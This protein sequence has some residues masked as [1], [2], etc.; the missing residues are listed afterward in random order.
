MREFSNIFAWE[1]ND[2][3]TYD[4]QVIEHRIPLKKEAIPFKKKLRSIS[5][6]LLSIMEKEIKKILNAQIIIRLRYS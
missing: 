2:L 6:L 4:T 5:P 1:Y 3:M